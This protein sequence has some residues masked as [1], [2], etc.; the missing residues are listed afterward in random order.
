[1][2][3]L[4]FGIIGTRASGAERMQILMQRGDVEVVA[5]SCP[6]P[7]RGVMHFEDEVGL[8]LRA[9][10]DAVIFAGPV[11]DTLRSVSA[12][13]G[14]G[15]HVLCLR[16]PGVTVE[17]AIAL[18]K[19][20]AAAKECLLQFSF[21][22]HYHGAVATAKSL[23]A[24]RSLGRLLTLRGVYS[25]VREPGRAG[26]GGA[27]FDKGLHMVDLMTHF[28]GPF[29]EVKSFIGQAVW[30]ESGCDDNAFA[31]LRT[32]D[33]VVAQL[34]ASAT[35]WRET[36]RLELGYENG[37]LWMDGLNGG[38]GGLSPE[39]LVVGR[40]KRDLQGRPIANPEEQVT[41]FKAENALDLELADFIHAIRG[42][43]P[44]VH[45]T[46]SQA[47]DAMNT[48]QRLYADDESWAPRIYDYDEAPAAA[49]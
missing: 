49:E 48:I 25:T 39:V 30:G 34:H 44:A 37:Y 20:E 18:R 24:D 19:A 9:D 6:G 45:G 2:K 41:E 17:D 4:R 14:R 43:G 1:M 46:S 22:L 12:A 10:L 16:P 36:F 40:M 5:S 8:L 35:W 11:R 3:P 26:R 38:N 7:A 31:M 29:E 42:L 23:A 33:G 27:L 28:A 21:P 47:F 13:L 32:H 15:L